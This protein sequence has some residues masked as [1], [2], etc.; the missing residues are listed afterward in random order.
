MTGVGFCPARRQARR[1]SRIHAEDLA[2][3]RPELQLPPPLRETTFE[4][5][6]GRVLVSGRRPPGGD[7][8][9]EFPLGL[10]KFA[11]Q[12]VVDLQVRLRQRLGSQPGFQEFL[13]SMKKRPPSVVGRT[14]VDLAG[15]HQVPL[16]RAERFPV[17]LPKGPPPAQGDLDDGRPL[18]ELLRKGR[19]DRQ[20]ED[21][22][23]RRE[24]SR[25]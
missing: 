12:L 16:Q 13:K 2:E 5:P 19:V 3:L 14:R 15:P 21:G 17:D 24:R 9:V 18:P 23:E 10:L 20:V 22:G 6:D 4:A 1:R 25:R 7:P 8:F 11:D